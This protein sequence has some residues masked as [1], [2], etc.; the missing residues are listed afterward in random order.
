MLSTS[1][2]GDAVS[3]GYGSQA[4]HRQGLAPCWFSTLAIAQPPGGNPG[5]PGMKTTPPSLP[6]DGALFCRFEPAS[7]GIREGIPPGVP[8][9]PPGAFC[10][11]GVCGP[12]KPRVATR[13]L[14][15][16]KPPRHPC[17]TTEHDF[18]VRTSI[19]W[20]TGRH[21]TRSPPAPA[22]GFLWERR[23]WPQKA[24]GGNPGTPGMKTTPPSMPH[25][26]A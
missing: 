15:A 20:H 11:S 12:K 5:T 25:D 7:H 17:R 14:R 1:P 6:H 13:G 24:P 4:G 2:H 18:P 9:L 19:A 10:G 22:G 8:Q 16:R 3:I 21:P 23:V 26:G